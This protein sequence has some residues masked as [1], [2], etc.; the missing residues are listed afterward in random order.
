MRV[1]AEDTHLVQNPALGALLQWRFAVE[2]VRSR[3]DAQP[4]PVLLLFFVMPVLLHAETLSMLTS[5]NRSS[6]LRFFA[7]TFA[8]APTRAAG[9][10]L[11]L[12][13]RISDMRTVSLDGIRIGL[14]S[15]LFTLDSSKTSVLPLSEASPRAA[16][17]PSVRTL[18]RNTEKFGAWCADLTLHEICLTLKLRL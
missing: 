6:G 11:G 14:A 13:E 15:R 1:L 12:H 18:I 3:N 17:P 10:L 16:I 2:Y 7:T 5:T 8:N 4:C 9:V